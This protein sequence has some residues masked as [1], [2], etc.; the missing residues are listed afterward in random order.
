MGYYLLDNPN[1]N[2]RDRGDGRYHGYPG[3]SRAVRLVVIHTSESVFDT[4]GEDTGAENVARYLSRVARAASYHAICDR[5][6]QVALLPFGHTAFG[7]RNYNGNA[8]HIAVAGQAS[9]W[10]T[11]SDEERDAILDNLVPLVREALDFADLPAVRLRDSEARGGGRGITSHAALDP[12]RRSD[13]GAEFPWDLLLQRLNG[14]PAPTKPAPTPKPTPKPEPK[15]EKNWTEKIVD[16]LPL[17]KQRTDLHRASE[18]DRVLQGLLVSHGVLDLRPNLDGD[19]FDGKFGKSTD[20]AV[21]KFQSRKGLTVD[22]VVGKN[23]WSAL[24]DV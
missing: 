24:L 22:G 14:E 18:A 20:A 4:E 5:D 3:R 19:R 7:A 9:K 15:P 2:A 17:L 11:L 10:P 13:P 1:P 21:R 6:S 23:T 8:I 16:E 12:S